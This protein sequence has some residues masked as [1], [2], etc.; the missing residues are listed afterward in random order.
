MSALFN[1]FP[2]GGALDVTVGTLAPDHY[3]SGLPFDAD[4][5]VSIDTATAIDHYHQGLPF[6]AVGR[7]AASVGQAVVRFGS[8]AAPFDATGRLATAA[9]AV[10]H[11]SSGVPYTTASSIATN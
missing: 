9:L 5:S 11:Y 1:R 8:G 2:S 7:I 3:S 10:D 4:G 6:T